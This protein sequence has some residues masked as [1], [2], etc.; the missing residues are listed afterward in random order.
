MQLIQ[1]VKHNLSTCSANVNAISHKSS[2]VKKIRIMG[3]TLY[4]LV[5]DIAV[6]VLKRDV[7]LKPTNTIYANLQ[8]R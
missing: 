8:I 5:S 2:Q 7:K 1:N 3:A 6:F 4:M